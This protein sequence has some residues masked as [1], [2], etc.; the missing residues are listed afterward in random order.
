MAVNGMPRARARRSR[1]A[2]RRALLVSVAFLPSVA[3]AAAENSGTTAVSPIT[4][5]APTPLGGAG[6][7]A[8]KLPGSTETLDAADLRRRGSLTITDA[9]EQ[10]TPGLSLSDAQGNGFA[11]TLNYRGFSASPLQGAPQGLAVYLGGVR[12]NE[13]FGDTVNWDLIP[14]VAVRRIEL[15]TSDPAFGLN[16]LGGALSLTLKTGRDSAGGSATLEGGS[17]GRI[18]GSMEYGA[19]KGPW[20]AYLAV[21]GGH[22]DGWRRQSSSHVARGYADL[23]WDEGPAALHLVIAGGQTRLGVVGPTP[24]DMLTADRRSVFTYPQTTDDRNTLVALNGSYTLSDAWSLQ[25]S[26]YGRTFR[27]SHVDGN[28]GNFEG[29]SRNAANPLFGTLCVEDDAFPSAIRPPAASFQ[30]LGSNIVPIGCPPLVAGQTKLCNGIPYGTVD[31]TNTR[32]ST[33]GV[34]AQ[35]SGSEHLFG[36]PNLFAAGLSFDESHIRFGADS[37]L[38]LIA[39]SLAVQSTPGVVVGAGSIIHTAGAIADS[40]VSLHGTTKAWGLYATDTLDLTD[41]LFLTVS[42]RFNGMRLSTTDQTGVSPDLNGEH[43][44]D[45]FNPAAGLAWKATDFVTLY[46]GYAETNRAPTILELSCSNPLKPCLLEN[47]LVSDP[48]LQQVVSRT[49]Q[50]GVRGAAPVAGGHLDWRI[51]AYRSENDD[52]IV[53]LASAIQG[54]GSY[55]NVPRTRREGVEA[56]V[57]FKADRWMAYASA[58]QVS[59]TY[60]FS[61]ALPSGNSPFADT[62]GNVTVSSGDRIGGIPPGRFKA[63]GDFEVTP[64]ITIGADVLGVS[65]QRRVG[66]EANQ[67]AQIPS[68]WVASAHADWV[69]GHGLEVFGR[70]DN[71][72]DRRYATFGTYFETDALRN[73]HPSP[74]PADPR[75][76]T[77][78]P[79]PPRSFLVGLRYR[80]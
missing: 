63:G 42:G 2:W 11:K 3:F 8:D 22:D 46:G 35:I 67:D 68:Y 25:A 12:L 10:R 48:P 4:V 77:D 23:G 15:V 56:E 64:A 80:W 6:V 36:R 7:E 58:S 57:N 1:D 55:A 37:T 49:W 76:N 14:E 24:V 28:N 59:A 38:G 13:A 40:P 79:A 51:G 9:L 52:D 39:A 73:L 50:A 43:R 74:L 27:Q 47:A 29:C 71:L 61:G 53:A 41:R 32:T 45:R 26:V 60:R 66:D 33:G 20:S 44:F 31:R 16:A 78:T 5:V 75:P 72:F 34:S 62:D 65:S 18:D 21:D 69:V 19:A 54:R 30:V 70:I 17:F